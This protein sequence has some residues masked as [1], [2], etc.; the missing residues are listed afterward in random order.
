MF[1]PC[2]H[3][4]FA[5]RDVLF[6]EHAD[7]GHKVDS[8]DAWHIPYDHDENVKEEADDEHEHKQEEELSDMDTTATKVHQE[9]EKIHHKA[10]E[11]VKAVK[12]QGGHHAKLNYLKGIKIML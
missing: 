9:E 6:H 7:E 1:D 4:V 2:T 10:E 5:S 12:H 8:Y 11:E 3:K